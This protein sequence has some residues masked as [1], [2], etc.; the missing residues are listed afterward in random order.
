MLASSDALTEKE[1]RK[2]DIA[3]D[4]HLLE[5]AQLAIS[6]GR[7]GRVVELARLAA[8]E[9][10]VD[11]MI[12]LAKHHKLIAVVDDLERIRFP[13]IAVSAASSAATLISSEPTLSGG[14]TSAVQSSEPILLRETVVDD[15]PAPLTPIKCVPSVESVL[16][17]SSSVAGSS[18]LPAAAANP[19]LKT[20]ATPSAEQ[21]QQSSVMLDYISNIMKMTTVKRKASA[22]ENDQSQNK[23][24]H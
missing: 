16:A 6:A 21:P 13:Q 17:A 15:V 14:A 11:L 23:R 1:R 10:T 24:I 4:R 9:K 5:L 12:Q 3:A 22:N 20:L 18:P 19:F 2:L 7:I 8:G